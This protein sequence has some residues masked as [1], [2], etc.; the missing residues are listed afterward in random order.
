MLIWY[1]G[2]L[3]ISN[4]QN[5]KKSQISLGELE[6]GVDFYLNIMRHIFWNFLPIKH[7]S[8]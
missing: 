2:K 6:G 3:N 4:P 7:K 5:G 8:S 1:S